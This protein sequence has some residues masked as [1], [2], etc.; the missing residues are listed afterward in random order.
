Q[1]HK[2][3]HTEK[4]KRLTELNKKRA[5]QYMWT[6]S[7]RFKPEPITNVKIHPNSRPIVLTVYRNNDKRNYDVYNPFK[8]T[9]FGLAELDELGLVTTQTRSGE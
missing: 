6:I 7:N 3:Q 5:K 4:V 9:D 2:R 1:V 8:F